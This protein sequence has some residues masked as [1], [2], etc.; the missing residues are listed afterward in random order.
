M[1]YSYILYIQLTAIELVE[2]GKD[3]VFF[4]EICP[5]GNLNDLNL[6]ASILHLMNTKLYKCIVE[7]VQA[8]LK[9][10]SRK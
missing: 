4:L 9:I 5:A 7:S 2:K 8:K 1:Y 6:R 10:A 3:G